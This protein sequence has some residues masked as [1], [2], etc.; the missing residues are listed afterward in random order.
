MPTTRS[1][2]AT[3]QA[4]TRPAR[5]QGVRQRARAHGLARGSRDTKHCIVAE[6]RPL[7]RNTAQPGLRYD[8]AMLYDTAGCARDTVGEAAISAAAHA[9]RNCVAIQSLI[10]IE[11]SCDTAL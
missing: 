2:R 10:V 8:A 11:W 7:C 6:G 3:I 5:A 4:T 9:E 1:G